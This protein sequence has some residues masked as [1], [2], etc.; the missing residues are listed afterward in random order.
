M[1]Y[2]AMRLDTSIRQAEAKAL[3]AGLGFKDIPPYYDVPAE[4]R[5]WLVFMELTL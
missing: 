1:D 4:M 3:Y 5:N 2:R